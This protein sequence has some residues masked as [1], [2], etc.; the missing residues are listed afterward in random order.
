MKFLWVFYLYLKKMLLK[1]SKNKILKSI[2]IMLINRK[3]F[4]HSLHHS[5]VT[6]RN[7]IIFLAPLLIIYD[8]KTW[9]FKCNSEATNL[10]L[11]H[12]NMRN[13]WILTVKYLMCFPFFESRYFN[14]AKIQRWCKC[15]LNV[16]PPMWI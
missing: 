10:I 1:L 3:H 12:L 14:K 16:V 13:P 11:P 9:S 7:W 15:R 5:H 8:K 4:S 6:M 2:L